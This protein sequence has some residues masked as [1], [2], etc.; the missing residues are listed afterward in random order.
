MSAFQEGRQERV[1]KLGDGGENGQQLDA[2]HSRWSS[3]YFPMLHGTVM[4]DSA[5]MECGAARRGFHS[6]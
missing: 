1:L 4:E 6:P 3:L 5:A 2:L